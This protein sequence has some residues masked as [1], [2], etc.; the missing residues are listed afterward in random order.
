MFER[1]GRDHF[2]QEAF[3]HRRIADHLRRD[4]LYRHLPF[5][6]FVLGQIDDAHAAAAQLLQ[7]G[8][9]CLLQEFGGKFV[10]SR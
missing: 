2:L 7:E 6:D 3:A 10:H 9:L 8:I 5:H 1:R 4:K